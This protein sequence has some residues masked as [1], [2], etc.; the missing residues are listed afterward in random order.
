MARV[1]RADR[2]GPQIVPAA[3][4]DAHAQARAIVQRAEAAAERQRQ[5]ALALAR[6][7]AQ[8]EL[9]AEWL[10]LAQQRDRQLAAIEPQVIEL[11][12]LASKRIIGEQLALA[13]RAIA[14]LV[15][16]LLA[17]VRRARQV[18]LR[19]HP[20][21]RPALEP[22]LAALCERAELA[23]SV[24]LELDPELERGD[25]VV[26]SD[27]GVLDARI[28]TQLQALSRALGVR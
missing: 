13:P 21:D 18:T 11:S 17:R 22:A 8:A 4:V 2:T 14:D 20:L 19:V 6:A 3:V 12:L 1:I 16:P 15:A 5:A 7:Q 26:I 27:I 23:A 24:Q 28:E 9:A 25:C 10:R